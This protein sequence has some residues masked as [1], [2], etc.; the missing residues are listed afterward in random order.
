M[1]RRNLRREFITLEEL[2][3]HLRANGHGMPERIPA[4]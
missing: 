2:Q 4:R 3:S 1:L